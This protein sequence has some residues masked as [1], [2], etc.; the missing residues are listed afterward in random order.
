MYS[1]YRRKMVLRT[2]SM[3]PD[4]GHLHSL[5]YRRSACCA[6]RMERRHKQLS[7]ANARVAPRLWLHG[8]VCLAAALLFRDSTPA[9][10]G[11]TLLYA[12]GYVICYR[13]MTQYQ[14][15]GLSPSSTDRFRGT[16]MVRK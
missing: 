7:R 13:A 9:L 1:I 14:R 6:G 4:A 11:F 5:I 12:A 16:R 10:I 2:A 15:D 3:Q 8:A